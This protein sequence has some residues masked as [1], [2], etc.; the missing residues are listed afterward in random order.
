MDVFM[1]NDMAESDESLVDCLAKALGTGV[2]LGLKAQGHHWNVTGSDFSEYYKFFKSIYTDVLSAVDQ[3]GEN[4]RKIGSLA[5][6]TLNDFMMLSTC[7]DGQVGTDAQKMCADLYAGNAKMIDCWNKV[8]DYA[9]RDN[10]QSIADFAAG[11]LDS[12]LK[13]Q[14][15][16]GAHLSA[17]ANYE[18]MD[19]ADDVVEMM[20]AENL[21]DDRDRYYGYDNEISF[22]TD[23]D[24]ALLAAV[25]GHNSAVVPGRRTNL[26]VLKTVYRRGAKSFFFSPAKEG[27]IDA[28][29]MRRTEAFLRLLSAGRPAT[30]SYVQDNDLL[31]LDHPR[32]SRKV[33]SELTASGHLVP[34]EQDLADALLDIVAKYGKFNEDETG[35]WAGYTPAAEND[36]ASIGVVCKNCVF[37]SEDENGNDVCQII[38]VQIEDLGKCRFA[39]IPDGV[40]SDE[41]IAKYDREKLNE[42]IEKMYYSKQL[43][44]S[45]KNESEYS[46]AEEAILAITEMSG[47]GYRLVP[48]VRAA[49]MR[50]VREGESPF[51]RATVLASALYK[52]K[53]ADLL[54]RQEN[55]G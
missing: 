22:G 51:D 52:S 29:A 25:E 49:W 35:V 12:H 14:W 55:K 23:T 4:M 34:E 54:P 41:A 8:F 53:D 43:S 6:Y 48:A 40:V 19:T 16:L 27:S 17:D 30:A 1:S 18:R 15:Q 3:T 39:V 44:V 11:R 42:D 31:P 2:V 45:L 38:D 20:Y 36:V 13:W 32:R 37:Y 24:N 28:A 26:N 10:V 9:T 21:E 5:P 47:Q 33:V 7:D 50:G 46:S